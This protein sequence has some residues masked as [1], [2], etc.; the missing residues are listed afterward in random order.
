MKAT[1]GQEEESNYCSCRLINL[2]YSGMCLHSEDLFEPGRL[3]RFALDLSPLLGTAV[4]VSA[5]IV[6]KRSLGAGLCYAGA[7]FVK[8]SRPWL[9]P[10]DEEN[11]GFSSAI[12][13]DGGD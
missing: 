5:H 7:R 1:A 12:E 9:G 3:Y 11:D 6:W 2:S 13:L 8:S 4:D 10:N